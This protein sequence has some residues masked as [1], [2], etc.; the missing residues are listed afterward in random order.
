MPHLR[1]WIRRTAVGGV[2]LAIALSLFAALTP[3]STAMAGAATPTQPFYLDLGASVSVGVQPTPTDP[4]GHPTIHGYANDLVAMAAANGVS[5]ALTRL[6]CPGE[7]VDTFI[8]G[9]DHCYTGNDTQLS[10]ALAFLRAHHDQTGLVTIDLGFNTIAP[11]FDGHVFDATCLAQKFATLPPQLSQ[12]VASL[13]AAAGPNVTFVGVG[14]Y[15]P[16]Y[17]SALSGASGQAFAAAS[18]GVMRAL[19]DVLQSVYSSFNVPFAKVA[20]AFSD[21]T[22]ALVPLA[23]GVTVTGNVGAACSLTWMCAPAPFG[24]NIHPTDAGYHVIARAI[25]AL[26]PS[27]L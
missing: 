21:H 11:C 26:I 24:P 23:K 13:K 19:N 6:G 14:H 15:D 25:A 7:S 3:F 4:K 16:F 22:H 2:T 5:L 20:E 9:G 12:V 8:N 10:D 1:R 17:A 18:V 27:S